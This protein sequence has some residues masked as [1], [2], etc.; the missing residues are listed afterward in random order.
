MKNFIEVTIT[1][2]QKTLVAVDTISSVIDVKDH[3]EIHTDKGIFTVE[4]S[5]DE[6]ARQLTEREMIC[7]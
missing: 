4:D 2:G 6:L 5:Y 3:R 7:D 1:K